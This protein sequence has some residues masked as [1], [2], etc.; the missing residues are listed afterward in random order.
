MAAWRIVKAA[1]EI[2]EH[3]LGGMERGAHA[4]ERHVRSVHIHQIDVAG[5]D[6]PGHAANIKHLARLRERSP[7]KARRVRVYARWWHRH[8]ALRADLSRKRAR[9]TSA[10]F[11]K[12]LRTRRKLATR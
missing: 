12:S 10:T 4:R 9:C 1:L 2:A 11:C 6:Y 7:R 5:E 8:P 3:D